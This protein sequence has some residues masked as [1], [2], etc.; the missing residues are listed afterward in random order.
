MMVVSASSY[1]FSAVP[2]EAS[3]LLRN[4]RNAFLTVRSLAVVDVSLLELSSFLASIA[5]AMAPKADDANSLLVIAPVA[6]AAE[7]IAPEANDDD[8]IPPVPTDPTEP[9][10]DV[11][12]CDVA[13]VVAVNPTVVVGDPTLAQSNPASPPV[14]TSRVRPGDVEYK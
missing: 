12:C 6:I 2:L 3:T 1:T 11:I 4:I 10:T 8:V 13:I 7:S 5:S 14:L 9:D